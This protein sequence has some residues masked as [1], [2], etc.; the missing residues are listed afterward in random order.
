MQ[1]ELILERTGKNNLEFKI[2]AL[3]KS[4]KEEKIKFHKLKFGEDSMPDDIESNNTENSLHNL[5]MNV[6]HHV[7]FYIDCLNV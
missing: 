5:F 2:A 3:N 7:F 4:L 6:L 1:N